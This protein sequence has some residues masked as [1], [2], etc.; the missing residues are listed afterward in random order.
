MDCSDLICVCIA[1]KNFEWGYL[2]NFIYDYSLILLLSCLS[3]V[4]QL[5]FVSFEVR[6][7]FVMSVTCVC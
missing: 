3:L 2:I 1:L 4:T 6:D 7:V 5:Y